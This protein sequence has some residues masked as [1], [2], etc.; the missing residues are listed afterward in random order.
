[1]SFRFVFFTLAFSVAVLGCSDPSGPPRIE[2]TR[3]APE[4]GIDLD[5]MQKTASG[6]YWRD[7]EVGTGREVVANQYAHIYYRGW[8]ANGTEFD[9]TQPPANPL[10]VWVGIGG[11]IRGFAEGMLGMREGGKRLFIVPP[12]L[13]YGSNPPPKSDIPKNAILVFEVEVVEV[14]VDGGQ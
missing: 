7:L 1:M 12:R 11:V 2:D 14:E 3:F 13:G 8:L 9:S 4:L 5:A 6:I 10:E